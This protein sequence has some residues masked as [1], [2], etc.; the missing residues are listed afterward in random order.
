MKLNTY[1]L[2]ARYFPSLIILIPFSLFLYQILPTDQLELIKES[3]V[4]EIITGISYNLILLYFLSS[5]VRFIGKF[6]IEK[7][8]YKNELDFPTT[9]FILLSDEHLSDNYK[10]KLRS[11]IESDFGFK[12]LNRDEE[13]EDLQTAKTMI[14]EAVALIRKRVG[15]GDLLLQHNIEYGFARNLIA[16]LVLSMPMCVV[17]I[18]FLKSGLL[19]NINLVVIVI[20]VIISLFSKLILRYLSELYAK[21]LF[22]EYLA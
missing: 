22:I 6:F 16:G 5:V 9:K 13:R 10:L 1:T 2:K 17:N 12:L 14:S 3:L 8:I 7:N 19:F 20:F 4:L 18:Y 21:R 15:T 11:K